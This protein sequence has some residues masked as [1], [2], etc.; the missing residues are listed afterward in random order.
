M[1]KLLL[2]LLLDM[3]WDTE[4][5]KSRFL[6]ILTFQSRLLAVFK[7]W[8]HWKGLTKNLGISKGN[9]ILRRSQRLNVWVSNERV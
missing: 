9:L 4:R 3:I 8:S 7:M 6:E 2:D 1:F 5:K